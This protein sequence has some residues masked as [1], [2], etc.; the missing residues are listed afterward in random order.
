[1]EASQSIVEQ[2]SR[3]IQRHADVL[4]MLRRWLRGVQRLLAQVLLLLRSPASL[5]VCRFNANPVGEDERC[6]LFAKL[7]FPD[8]VRNPFQTLPPSEADRCAASAGL[9]LFSF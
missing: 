9:C 8:L 6:E 5:S 3:A 2:L 1:M 7:E 4:H